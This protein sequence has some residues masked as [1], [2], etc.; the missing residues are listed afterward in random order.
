MCYFVR[1]V[2]NMPPVLS[3]LKGKVLHSQSREIINNVLR[4]MEEEAQQ[5]SCIIPVG[6]AQE[7]T[8]KAV[9][10]AER[11][12]RRIKYQAKSIEAASISFSTPNKVRNKKSSVKELDD[13]DLCVV[14]RTVYDFYKIEK[15]VLTVALLQQRLKDSIGFKGCVS[16]LRK[17]LQTMGFKWQSTKSNRRILI[18]KNNIRELRIQYLKAIQRYR[19]ERRPIIYMDE[20]Y[21]HSSHTIKKTWSDDSTEGLHQPISRGERL[22]IIHAGG[23][24]WF[25]KNALQT[26]NSKQR[27]GDYHKEMNFI[28]FEKWLRE[29]LIP[30]LPQKTVLVV[31]NAAYHNVLS[32]RIPNSNS[33]KEDML[34]WL[35][36][37]GIPCSSD[38]LKPEL[39][40]LIQMHKPRSKTMLWIIYSLDLVTQFYVYRPIT[41]I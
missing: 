30:N 33:L 18:E 17:I 20:S 1:C 34:Q 23:E 26:W 9:G 4:F 3:K 6:K 36:S 41:R 39:Y 37:Q 21:I 8:A 24:N 7:R 32:K 29:K 25:V 10:V 19:K 16:S 5:G 35:S 28:N 31:D 2:H 11:T 27:K 38:M 14:R 12:V 15:R 40:K 22:I 13:F